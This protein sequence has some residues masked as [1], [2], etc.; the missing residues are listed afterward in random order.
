MSPGSVST[1]IVSVFGLTKSVVSVT[2]CAV[3]VVTVGGRAE[4]SS[5][6]RFSELRPAALSCGRPAR[7]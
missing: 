4:P 5:T 7:R 6:Y 3:A 1:A 2:G